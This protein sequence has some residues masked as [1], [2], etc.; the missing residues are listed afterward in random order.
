[1]SQRTPPRKL[2][3]LTRLRQP[4]VVVNSPAPHGLDKFLQRVA[5]LTQPAILALGVFGYFYTVV[6]VFQNQQLQEQ[7][8]KLELEKSAAEKQLTLLLNQQTKVSGDIKL[9]QEN[10]KKERLR[11]LRLADDVA[12]A[13]DR[14]SLAR[15]KSAEIESTLQDELKIQAS[16]ARAK[17]AEIESTLQSQLKILDKSRWELVLIDVDTSY[18]F[19]KI[20]A[21]LKSIQIALIKES[22]WPKPYEELIEAVEGAAKKG[23]SLNSIPESYYTELKGFIHT[24]ELALQCKK[25]DFGAIYSDHLAQIAILDQQ[26]ESE[27]DKYV[28][29]VRSEYKAK[30]QSVQ[31]T[32]DFKSRSRQV[33]RVGK[34]FGV[35]KIYRDKIDTLRKE[36]DD[37]AI[38]VLN[39]IRKSKG[40]TR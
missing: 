21:S 5:N 14:E 15:A 6:P 19:R 40:A 7:T 9:L 36:C 29:N 2:S 17:S 20:N 26:V 8:A 28:E 33:I 18:Y 25:V 38:S 13:K 12:Q 30:N 16:L 1:M 27:L 23:S 39:E 37:K 10:W 32:D 31:I 4:A 24:K 22:D 34:V 35:E 11:N 3:A